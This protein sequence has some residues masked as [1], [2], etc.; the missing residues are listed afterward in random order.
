MTTEVDGAIHLKNGGGEKKSQMN[1]LANWCSDKQQPS[2]CVA[3]CYLF[4]PATVVHIC[5]KSKISTI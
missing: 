3:L 5:Y 4:V 2:S 1:T